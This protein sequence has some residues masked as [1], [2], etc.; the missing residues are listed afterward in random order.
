MLACFSKPHFCTSIAFAP[1]SHGINLADKRIHS[2]VTLL[3]CLASPKG[4]GSRFTDIFTYLGLVTSFVKAETAPNLLDLPSAPPLPSSDV[5]H[6]HS[7]SLHTLL[8]EA[9][10]RPPLFKSLIPW[11]SPTGFFLQHQTLLLHKGFLERKV[12]D[13]G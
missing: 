5:H 8:P 13:V 2:I 3:C 9:A 1:T 6:L 7:S 11:G 12:I 4:I 10:C